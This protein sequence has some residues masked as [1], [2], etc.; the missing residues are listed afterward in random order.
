MQLTPNDLILLYNLENLWVIENYQHSTKRHAHSVISCI[1]LYFIMESKAVSM[2]FVGLF[3]ILPLRP[4]ENN[5]A[6]SN[7]L[8]T[9][10]CMQ[11]YL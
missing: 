4:S 1:D 5:S 8:G 2:C 11:F 6:V 7:D 3:H 9:G 10:I